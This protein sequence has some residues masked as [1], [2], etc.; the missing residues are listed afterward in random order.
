MPLMFLGLMGVAILLTRL[1]SDPGFSQSQTYVLFLLF[2]SI[3][4]WVTETI[5]AFSVSLFIIAFLVF[6]LGSPL[7]NSQPEN[8][9]VYVN[10]FSSSIIW[11]ML[12]GFF[13]ASAMTKTG[14]D[15]LLLKMAVKVGGRKPR[16]FLL[17]MMTT[18]ML[19]SMIMSNTATTAM[20]LA[21]LTPL[22]KKLD[23]TPGTIKSFLVGV[24]L[25]ASTGGMA[26][27]IGSPPNAIAVGALEHLQIHVN[28]LQWMQVGLPLALV[29]TLIGY[30]IIVWV[31]QKDN[32][33]IPLEFLEMGSDNKPDKEL[34][35]QRNRVF[36]VL[37]ITVSLWLTSSWHGI[38]VAAVSAV[39][40]VLLPLF[41][42]LSGKDVQSL[43]WDTLLLVAGGLSLGIALQNAGILDFY[44]SKITSLGISPV[45]L[46]ASLGLLTMLFSNI[47]SNSA[48]TT[49][50]VP[51]GIAMLAGMQ[52]E[53]A[54]VVGLSASTAMLL[55]V[56]TPPNAIAF[57]TGLMEQKDFRISGLLIGLLGPIITV[58]WVLFIY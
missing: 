23:K 31:F 50:L 27:V 46:L 17:G 7:F 8:T 4:L 45:Y 18:T 6:A 38:G 13:L 5:P 21:A 15:A 16:Y 3:G 49:I 9:A 43:P 34:I 1:V 54:L 35:F 24:P 14:I 47:M 19:A 52:T 28:F 11:L 41:R 51:V 57:S 10:T 37:I 30:L 39:P 25:A 56:S 55:P 32:E 48:T 22:L 2:F 44:T 53:A 33:S 26:T 20:V 42:I 29:L 58:L 40:I 36:A 12:G